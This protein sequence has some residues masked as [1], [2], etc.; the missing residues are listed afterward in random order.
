MQRQRPWLALI[1]VAAVTF[2]L[3]CGTLSFEFVWDDGD[4]IISNPL[5]RSW[6]S[7]PRI[8]GSDLWFHTIHNQVYYRPLFL[9]WEILNIK[10]FGV[11]TWGW[12]LTAVLLHVLASCSVY[13]LARA[14]KTDHW[15]SA[16]AALM[17][18]VHPIHVECASW[19]SASS[20]SMVAVFYVLAFIS[21]LR[22]REH[23]NH[24]R[25]WQILSFVLLAC[26][27]LTKEMAITF[28][29]LVAVHEW[30]DHTHLRASLLYRMRRSIQAAVPY[31]IIT[32]GYW[33][34]RRMALHESAGFDPAH[35]NLDVILTLPLVL[36]TY[37]KLLLVPTGMTAG[38]YIPYVTSPGFRNF[39][40]PVLAL[41]AVTAIV[42]FLSWRRKDTRIAFL[43]AWLVVGLIPVLYL[44]LFA[45][46]AG[47]RDRYI[48]L[49][50]MGFAL[51]LA[52]ALR[53]VHIPKR[54]SNQSIQ[55]ALSVIVGGAF[56]VGSLSQQVYWANDFLLFYRA[57]S[58]YPHNNEGVAINL[59]NALIKKREYGRAIPILR[60]VIEENPHSGTP[61]AVLAQAYLHAGQPL[62]ARRELDEALRI[63]PELLYALKSMTDVANLYGELGDYRKAISL[64]TQ[65]LQREPD[66]YDALYNGGLTYFL[67][68]SDDQAERLFSHAIQVAPGLDGPIFYLGRICLRKSQPDLAESY[69]KQ[70]LRINPTGYGLHYWLGQALAARGQLGRARAAYAEELKLYPMNPD[71]I[72]QLNPPQQPELKNK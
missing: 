20:D 63:A 22:A 8:F 72:A 34:V 35:T 49:P 28:M 37:L 40:L 51:L 9:V 15:T 12:H 69:F 10:L 58:L 70:A 32:V 46:G 27:L 68:G 23:Q 2:V 13:W 50:S 55:I 30:L 24:S 64:Y 45:P 52:I 21:Y 7:I 33:F 11:R 61:H 31:A 57:L 54:A 66:F 47:V 36:F 53:S 71:A 65:V 5:I 3:Y 44:R 42:W 14:L 26:A 59:A 60:Q 17:F 41:L 48:Y 39:I 4:Q 38:Y 25:R 43:A 62:D 67:M 6:H 56:F 16:L 29:L 19:I 18:G 1:F